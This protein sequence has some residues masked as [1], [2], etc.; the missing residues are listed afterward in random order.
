[1]RA[2]LGQAPNRRVTQR[3]LYA[4]L[5]CVNWDDPAASSLLK[6]PRSPHGTAS[7]AVFTDRQVTQY[8]RLTEWV[9]RVAQKPLP[10]DESAEP[11]P[12]DRLAG[13]GTA[14]PGSPWLT[15]KS[16]RQTTNN[17][18]PG[19][20][21]LSML[22]P[23][24]DSDS[25]PLAP[26]SVKPGRT[27]RTGRSQGVKRVLATVPEGPPTSSTIADPFDPSTYNRGLPSGSAAPAIL[28]T[29]AAKAL[30]VNDPGK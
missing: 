9:Y 5:Q 8:R 14:A 10:P 24:A 2:P 28:S 15:P 3:N 11:S 7:A 18:Q 12:F 20:G 27:P 13:G 21:N 23:A 17:R 26:G 25:G 30:N 1:M 29:P 6:L 16:V 22:D 4:T 19:Y